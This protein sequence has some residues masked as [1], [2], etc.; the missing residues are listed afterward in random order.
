MLRGIP[1]SSG[2]V[3]GP[4]FVVPRGERLTTPGIVVASHLTPSE[5][6]CLNRECVL[7][8]ATESG[9]DDSH[10]AVL[11]RAL[12]VPAVVSVPTLLSSITDGQFLILDGNRG[13]LF[14]SPDDN[15]IAD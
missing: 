9:G 11:A 5:T 1:V 6:A 10:T 2:V 8:F 4:S 12:E 15:T 13:E 3:A 14:L 7:A